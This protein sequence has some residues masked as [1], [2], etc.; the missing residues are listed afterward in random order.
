MA[1]HSTDPVLGQL[2]RAVNES[3]QAQVPV[4]VSTNGTVLTGL[5]IA[6]DTYFAELAAG[7][8]L[9]GALEPGSGMLGK[10]YAKDVSAE[11]GYHLHIR[12]AA[13]DRLWRVSLDSV[14]GWALGTPEAAA[15]ED[16]GPFAR[17]LGA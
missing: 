6:Q 7:N 5:L 1:K 16:K 13:E 10:E 15:T 4:V 3:G 2:V 17:L 12:A 9:M 8:P 14:D 11:A